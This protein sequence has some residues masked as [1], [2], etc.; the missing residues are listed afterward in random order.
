M[1][2]SLETQTG[3]PAIRDSYNLLRKHNRAVAPEAALLMAASVDAIATMFGDA[4]AK[5]IESSES[6]T[7][8][9]DHFNAAVNAL[10]ERGVLPVKMLC[11]HGDTERH[12]NTGHVE[13]LVKRRM[14]LEERKRKRAEENDESAAVRKAKAKLAKAKEDDGEAVAEPAKKT[15]AKAKK[16]KKTAEPEVEE[17]A[18]PVAEPKRRNRKTVAEAEPEAEEEEAAPDGEMVESGEGAE[19]A[20]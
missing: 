7:V 11:E 20:E 19:D 8:T 16:S 12:R 10:D 2:A 14:N 1:S 5:E 15:K 4:L 17:D 6:N 3:I 9:A 18:A 13:L